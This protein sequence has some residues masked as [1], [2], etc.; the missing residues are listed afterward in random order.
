[1]KDVDISASGGFYGRGGGVLKKGLSW[2]PVMLYKWYDNSA[3][4][5]GDLLLLPSHDE[6]SHSGMIHLHVFKLR[7]LN[8]ILITFIIS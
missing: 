5:V 6:K 8:S 7:I 4:L 1:V 3:C 2:I